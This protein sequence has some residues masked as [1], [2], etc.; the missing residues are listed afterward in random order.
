[1]LERLSPEQLAR[2]AR[3]AADRIEATA[4]TTPSQPS[5]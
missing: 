3:L 2:V 4:L 5:K 1:V